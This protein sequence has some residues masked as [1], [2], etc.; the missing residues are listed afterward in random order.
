MFMHLLMVIVIYCM[1]L[2]RNIHDEAIQ[3][4]V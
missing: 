4:S 2:G 1:G 3:V